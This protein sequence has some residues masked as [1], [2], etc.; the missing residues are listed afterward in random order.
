MES[1]FIDIDMKRLFQG[2]CQGG[3]AMVKGYGLDEKSRFLKNRK[4]L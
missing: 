3:D 2:K 4:D 1:D